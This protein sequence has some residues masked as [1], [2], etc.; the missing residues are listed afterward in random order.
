[1][2]ASILPPMNLMCF[3]Y[4]LISGFWQTFCEVYS[5]RVSSK[6]PKWILKCRHTPKIHCASRSP[7]LNFVWHET[8]K[9]QDLLS[10]S[11]FFTSRS[12]TYILI[13]LCK[14][15]PLYHSIVFLCYFVYIRCIFVKL[16]VW[17]W[18][19]QDEMAPFSNSLSAFSQSD[20]AS[21]Q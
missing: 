5:S 17:S 12:C 4:K 16:V 9:K 10:S 14:Y 2:K 1:M 18:R 13:R 6:N 8:F 15:F 7:N 3:L 21:R 20:H 19:V 11:F